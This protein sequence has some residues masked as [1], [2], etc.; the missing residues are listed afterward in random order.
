M[1]VTFNTRL[2]SLFNRFAP[3]KLIDRQKFAEGSRPGLFKH[4]R[5]AM[6]AM[7]STLLRNGLL[8]P[9]EWPSQISI[10]PS[11]EESFTFV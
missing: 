5:L 7:T 9:V 1:Q 11:T 2:R 4:R 6:F 10:L 3:S 8:Q